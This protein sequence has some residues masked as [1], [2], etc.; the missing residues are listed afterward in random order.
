MK[1]RQQ[2][3]RPICPEC[4]SA[5]VVVGDKTGSCNRCGEKFPSKNAF[6]YPKGAG[7]TRFSTDE[8][9]RCKHRFLFED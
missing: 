6:D 9:E 2:R 5:D 4:G 3:P 8:H 7:E 1:K